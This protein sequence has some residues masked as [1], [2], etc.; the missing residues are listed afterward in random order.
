MELLW[1]TVEVF[2]YVGW[3]LTLIFPLFVIAFMVL[4]RR[5]RK[6]APSHRTMIAFLLVAIC[7][8]FCIFHIQSK[9]FK[10]SVPGAILSKDIQLFPKGT[11]P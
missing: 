9:I 10:V 3:I 8:G 6:K 11:Y 7:G 5:Y 4:R 2:A 1:D